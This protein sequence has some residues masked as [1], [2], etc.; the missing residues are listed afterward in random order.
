MFNELKKKSGS[1]EE[2]ELLGGKKANKRQS[3]GDSETEGVTAAEDKKKL[4][5]FRGKRRE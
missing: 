1:Q 4:I 5:K 2:N 3:A